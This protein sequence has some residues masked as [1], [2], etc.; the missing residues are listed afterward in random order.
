[1]YSP[2]QAAD[3]EILDRPSGQGW[4]RAIR[5]CYLIDRLACGGTESQLV[6]LIDRLDRAKVQPFLCILDGRDKV[7]RCFEPV[8]CS[9]KRF[10]VRSLARPSAMRKAIRFAGWLRAQQVDLLQV[11][12]PDSTYFGTFAARLARVPVIHTRRNVGYSL[13]RRHRLLGRLSTQLA[14]CTIAN[15]EAARRVCVDQ[16]HAHP[17]SV[18]VL[19]NGIDLGRFNAVPDLASTWRSEAPRIGA[20]ANLRAVKGLDVLIEAAALVGRTFPA[21]TFVIAGEGTERRALQRL[22]DQR[23]LSRQF[24][25]LGEVTDAATF[26]ANI[27]I[28][29]SSSHSEGLSNAVLEYMAA[30]RAIVA[31]AVGGNVELIDVG[32]TG[33]LVPANDPPALAQN[34]CHLLDKPDLA[35]SFGASAKIAVQAFFW[36]RVA[37]LHEQFYRARLTEY[38]SIKA[39]LRKPS[40]T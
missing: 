23:G 22:V 12:F 24:H 5:V 4:H 39:D 37:E 32:R 9:I 26:L 33:L 15:C 7:S 25:L 17:A 21:A 29:V 11:H 18:E 14:L 27:D 2:T 6:G 36:P 19:P 30:G 31:T 38:A 34:I 13:T 8:N 20:I 40:A 35:A 28:A 3:P 16:E 1:M 10:G